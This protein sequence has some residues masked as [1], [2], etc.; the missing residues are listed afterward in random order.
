[1]EINDELWRA[2]HAD[3]KEQGGMIRQLHDR[4]GEMDFFQHDRLIKLMDA[5]KERIAKLK[6]FQGISEG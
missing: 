3:L 1:M 5:Y 4:N 2:E 6:G